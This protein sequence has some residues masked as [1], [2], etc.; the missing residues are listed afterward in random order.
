[1]KRVILASLVLATTLCCAG[2]AGAQ[3]KS[4]AF[5]GAGPKFGPPKMTRGPFKSGAKDGDLVRFPAVGIAMRQPAGFEKASKFEGFEQPE[6]RSS[7]MAAS[8]P[9]PYAEI[10][11]GFN[12][13]KLGTRGMNLLEKEDVKIGELP[14][15]LVHFEQSALGINF[16]KWS[17]IFGN[18]AKT[19]IVTAAFPKSKADELSPLLKATVLGVVPDRAAAASPTSTVPFTI[20]PAG[21]LQ[22][23]KGQMTR[24]WMYSVDGA[25]PVKSPASPLF[26]AAESFGK[27]SLS[28]RKLAAEDRLRKLANV[29]NPVIRSTEAVKID[30][31]EGFESTADAEDEK[32]ATPI[33]VYQVML[34][35]DNSYILLV[36]IVGK[37]K[38]EEY[39]PAFQQMAQSLK[40]KQG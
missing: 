14:A 10:S 31:L 35:T 28:N 39:L 27:A 34:F 22:L 40:R 12:K 25:F 38:A 11:A 3:P 19:T 20:T 36:G 8:I 17:V 7:V 13:E 1:M 30:G 24:A 29:K 16:E 6:T 2:L 21:N 33:V 4:K 15:V 23:S 32:S 5:P 9:G 26:L 37:E 18:E